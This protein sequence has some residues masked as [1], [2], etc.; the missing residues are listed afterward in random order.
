[1]R[2]AT[3]GAFAGVALEPSGFPDDVNRPGFPSPVLRPGEVYRNE[4]RL[5]FTVT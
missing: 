4:M 3:S 5:T 2:V 1:M